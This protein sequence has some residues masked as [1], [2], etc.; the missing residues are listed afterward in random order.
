[1]VAEW[2][3]DAL[4]E[5]DASSYE[6]TFVPI[7]CIESSETKQTQSLCEPAAASDATYV[8]EDRVDGG[9]YPCRERRLSTWRSSGGL[10]WRGGLWMWETGVY[11]RR[12]I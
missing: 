7:N 5:E 10:H 2:E 4:L 9:R 12:R 11:L 6:A 1:M 8:Q 3:G